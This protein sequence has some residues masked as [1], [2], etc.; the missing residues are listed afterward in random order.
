MLFRSN[1]QIEVNRPVTTHNASSF[2]NSIYEWNITPDNYEESGIILTF[3]STYKVSKEQ[4]DI[5]SKIYF[6]LGLM[7]IFFLFLI[8]VIAYKVR[9]G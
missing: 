1:I 6:A 3:P 9:R 8:G 5:G 2:H 4:T 7:I